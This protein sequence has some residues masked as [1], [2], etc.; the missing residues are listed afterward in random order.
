MAC[1]SFPLETSLGAESKT[2]QYLFPESCAGAE[3]GWPR[4]GTGGK[5][6]S[7]SAPLENINFGLGII[8]F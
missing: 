3:S 7:P 6:I 2:S 1:E 4:L 5:N 8:P